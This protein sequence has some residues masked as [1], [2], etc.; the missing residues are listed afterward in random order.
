MLSNYQRL[1][2]DVI[3]QKTVFLKKKEYTKEYIYK[4]YDH[5]GHSSTYISFLRLG[6]ILG[7]IDLESLHNIKLLDVGYGNG[8]FLKCAQRYISSCYGFEI[9]N[10]L[11]PKGCSFIDDIY[12]ENFDIVC[13]FD[14]L[15]H[16]DDIYEIQNLKAQYICI[17]VPECHY[18]NDSWFEN[19]H[20]R[21]P[22]EHLWH[23]NK[24]SLKNFMQEIGYR[25]ICYSDV[26][27]TIRKP[28][29]NLSNI[30]TGMFIRC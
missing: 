12:K 7:A 28:I 5:Y 29:N 27:D 1:N 8:D 26:E 14:V 24:L 22:D 19:W 15:E 21:R 23:F 6:F 4:R 11:I 17:S 13:F 2:N 30:L 3:K 16:F 25:L 18:I 9:N 10:Y 20:H